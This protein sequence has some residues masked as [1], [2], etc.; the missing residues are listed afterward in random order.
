L[1]YKVWEDKWINDLGNT[2]LTTQLTFGVIRLQKREK[3]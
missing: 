2:K 3:Y 1:K